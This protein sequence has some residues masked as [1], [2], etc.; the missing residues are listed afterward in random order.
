MNRRR[1]NVVLTIT[2]LGLPALLTAQQ[3]PAQTS[4]NPI[5]DVFKNSGTR[6][7]RSL[8]AAFEI[9]PAD[10]YGY[11]PTPEQQ[12]FGYVAHH[13]A[14]ANYLLCSRFSSAAVDTLS[15]A[16]ASQPKDSLIAALKKSF[17]FCDSALAR[18]T[19][20]NLAEQVDYAGRSRPRAAWVLAYV[21]DLVDHYSQLANYMR[22]NGLLPPT[23]QP[24]PG[25]GGRGGAVPG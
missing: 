15:D 3:Q 14:N 10:K 19:D 22:L 23:A 4:A 1:L 20:A 8:V 13:L 18:I 6:A 9:M 16:A 2:V 12:T 11:K 17:V 5:T 21:T 7:A 25:R 24:Q